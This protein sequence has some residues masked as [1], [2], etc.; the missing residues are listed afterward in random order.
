MVA[1]SGVVFPA[2]M[3]DILANPMVICFGSFM[4][5]STTLAAV[6]SSMASKKAPTMPDATRSPSKKSKTYPL[7]PYDIIQGMERI[8]DMMDETLQICERAQCSTQDALH[9]KTFPFGL[10]PSGDAYARQ[11]AKSI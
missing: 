9:R 11:A 1:R 5:T 3:A 10:R 4:A 8:I 6:T 7:K 2:S